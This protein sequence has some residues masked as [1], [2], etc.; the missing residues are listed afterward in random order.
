M[1]NT[2]CFFHHTLTEALAFVYDFTIENL[3]PQNFWKL[4]A[5]TSFKPKT[6]KIY[7]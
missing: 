2:Y 7:S 3:I 6:G 4:K 1:E 5:G